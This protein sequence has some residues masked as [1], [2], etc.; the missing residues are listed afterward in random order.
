MLDISNTVCDKCG[1]GN[2]EEVVEEFK[3][4]KNKPVKKMSEAIKNVDPYITINAVMTY[5]EHTLRCLN[6]GYELKFTPGVKTMSATTLNAFSST[7][8]TAGN[9]NLTTEVNKKS[10]TYLD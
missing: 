1:S 4:P 7:T 8:I 5:H 2:I 6:C 3:K 9:A 10:H